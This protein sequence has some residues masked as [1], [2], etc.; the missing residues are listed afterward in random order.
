[1]IIEL[2]CGDGSFLENGTGRDI[3]SRDGRYIGIDIS[4]GLLSDLGHILEM[5]KVGAVI[6]ADK[7]YAKSVRFLGIICIIK[8]TDVVVFPNIPGTAYDVKVYLPAVVEDVKGPGKRISSAG[9]FKDGPPIVGF[10]Q[11]HSGV[12]IDI[13]IP[14]RNLS[15]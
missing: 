4:D 10:W 5:S 7:I 12:S 14:S 1:M 3:V 2:G 15:D 11:T 8:V 6:Q 9:N 13:N